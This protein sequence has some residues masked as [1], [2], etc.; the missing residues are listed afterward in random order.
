[1]FGFGNF[2][3]EVIDRECLFE[4]SEV[5]TSKANKEY[6]AWDVAYRAL[7]RLTVRNEQGETVGFYENGS[8]GNAQNQPSRADAHDLAYKSSIS[9]SLKRAAIALGDQF[10]LSLYN[11]GQTAALVI[12]TLVGVDEAPGDLQTDIPQQVSLGNDEVESPEIDA[13]TAPMTDDQRK[14]ALAAINAA[15]SREMLKEF[16]EAFSAH[17]DEPFT[18]DAGDTTTLKAIITARVATVTEGEK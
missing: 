10:G 4:T 13:V 9:L 8:V 17:L 1:M 3:I 18:N 2:D 16:W 6:V 11:K 12:R 7:V 14:F 5:K 15:S